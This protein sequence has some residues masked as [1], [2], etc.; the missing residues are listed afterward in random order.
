MNDPV[1]RV[2][3]PG[4]AERVADAYR[5]ACA[6][7]AVTRWVLAADPEAGI[8][9][10]ADSLSR[11][12]RDGAVVIAEAPDGRIDGVST[13]LDVESAQPVR[14]D[15]AA[16]AA[17]AAAS[18]N[19]VTRRMASV[20]TLT[21]A[22]H[23]DPPHRYLASMGVRTTMRGRGIG[24]ALLR[25]GLAHADAVRRPVYLEASTERN[26]A[27]YVRH[28][29]RPCGDPIALPDGGPLLRPLWREPRAP[30]RRAGRGEP[31]G[32]HP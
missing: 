16:L 4:E 17:N 28:G 3:R 11:T 26:A 14:E 5:A 12:V 31:G 29:F 18:S 10:V 32:V 21:A 30:R 7:E 15:A 25:F 22:R 24:G 9:V 13:W 6:D 8:D 23:P 19:A 20:L 2:A 1:I 27:L